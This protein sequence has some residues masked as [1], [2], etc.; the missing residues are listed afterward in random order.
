MSSFGQGNYQ[1]T[2]IKPDLRQKQIVV[3]SKPLKKDT[4]ILIQNS[5]KAWEPAN[6]QLD[7]D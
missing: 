5:R 4:S 3:Y 2:N 1:K 6:L 7:A